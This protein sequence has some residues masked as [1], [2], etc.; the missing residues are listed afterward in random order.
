MIEDLIRAFAG[1][2]IPLEKVN[3]L[4]PFFKKYLQEEGAILQ[5][6]T[7]R[8]IYLLRIFEKHH[9]DLVSVFKEKP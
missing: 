5:A 2:N 1:V 8:Q 3:A 7:L 9:E 4:L 6:T